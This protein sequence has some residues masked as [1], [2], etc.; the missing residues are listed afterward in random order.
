MV[1]GDQRKHFYGAVTLEE[2]RQRLGQYYTLSWDL[3]REQNINNAQPVELIFLYRQGATG[4]QIKRKSY[5]YNR[6]VKAGKLEINIIGDNYLKGGRVLSW[7]AELRQGKKLI[8][9]EESY[10]WK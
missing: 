9:S 2:Q 5:T 1:R 6:G 10:L 3:T 4:A 7:R 8:T